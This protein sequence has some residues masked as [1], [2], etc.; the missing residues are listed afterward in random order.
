MVFGVGEI[1]RVFGCCG[2]GV[3]PTVLNDRRRN[4]DYFPLDLRGHLGYVGA[5][6]RFTG[7]GQS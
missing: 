6:N 7:E 1:R 3:V 5:E 2:I 4:F